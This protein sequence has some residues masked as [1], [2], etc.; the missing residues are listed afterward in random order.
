MGV[1][2]MIDVKGKRSGGE[3]NTA[4]SPNVDQNIHVLMNAGRTCV[5]MG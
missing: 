3:R 5:L 4:T 1:E 2:G